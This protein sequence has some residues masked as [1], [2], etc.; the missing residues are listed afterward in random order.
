MTKNMN[1]EKAFLQNQKIEKRKRTKADE[2]K[3]IRR[4]ES[5]IDKSG[6]PESPGR[7]RFLK[8]AGLTAAA[9]ATGVGLKEIFEEDEE[10]KSS[11]LETMAD[12]SSDLETMAD[13]SSDLETM[14]DKSKGEAKN[15]KKKNKEKMEINNLADHYLKAYLELS[16]DSEKFPGKIFEKDLLIAQQCQESRGEIDAKSRSGALGEM[17]NMTSSIIDVTRYLNIL[18]RNTGFEW[19]GPEELSKNDR[20]EIKELIIQKSDYSRAFGKIYLM[21]LWDD[22][23]GYSVGRRKAEKGDVAS[24]QTELMGAYNAGFSRVKEKSLSE[25]KK[26]RE[27]YRYKKD[28]KSQKEFRAYNE[29]I[30]YVE[31]IFNYKK[32]IGNIREAFKKG[33]VIFDNNEDYAVRELCLKLDEAGDKKEELKKYLENFKRINLT[34]KKKISFRDI[35]IILKS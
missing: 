25:W 15:S 32:R 29:V 23:Y 7:R 3:I 18:K 34:D 31:K 6:K 19:N 21:Q 12:K 4:N 28:K 13:K 24:A 8:A 10:K 30:A 14:A 17:Q 11:D 5:E 35:D 33:V 27:K 22:K 1:I 16:K 20:K 2:P 26:L 9:L